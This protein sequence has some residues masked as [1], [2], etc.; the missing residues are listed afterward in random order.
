MVWEDKIFLD[1]SIYWKHNTY[2]TYYQ[3]DKCKK[4]SVGFRTPF[5]YVNGENPENS[6]LKHP[7]TV[8]TTPQPQTT[9]HSTP[10]HSTIH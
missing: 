4:S 2:E 7:L 6:Q 1:F 3:L 5:L 9:S 8:T 10:L